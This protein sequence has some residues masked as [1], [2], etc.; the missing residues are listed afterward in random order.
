MDLPLWAE[1]LLVVIALW[2][3]LVVALVLVGRALVA[4]E[5]A[6]LVPN[7]VRLFAGLLRDARVPL[8]AKVVLGLASLW[9]ASPIDLIPD[10]IP[11][12]GMFDDAI[13]A[14]LALRFL[15]GTTEVAIVREHWPGDPMTLER[16]LRLASWGGG[17]GPRALP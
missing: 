16:L 2:A 4:R 10:F 3:V 1:V 11:V 7:L 15:L 17:G 14:A 8:R 9:L 12:V 6:L 5:I 13:V